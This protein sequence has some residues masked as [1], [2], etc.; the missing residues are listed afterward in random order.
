MAAC[1]G[2]AML[3]KPGVVLFAAPHGITE[4]AR[5]FATQVNAT[6]SMRFVALNKNHLDRIAAHIG[7]FGVSVFNRAQL[8]PLFAPLS[9]ASPSAS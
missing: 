3:V 8:C 5:Q 2:M 4:Q 9:A 1:L 6:T 7:V